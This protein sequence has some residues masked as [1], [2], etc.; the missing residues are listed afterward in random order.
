MTKMLTIAIV[1]GAALLMGCSDGT[2]EAAQPTALATSAAP[3]AVPVEATAVPAEPTA[4]PS[5]PTVDN[6]S[7]DD[8]ATYMEKVSVL[9]YRSAD[10]LDRAT[11]ATTFSDFWPLRDEMAKI[12]D[13]VRELDA[14]PCAAGIQSTY[15]QGLDA[16][17]DALAAAEEG[18]VDTANSKLDLATALYN[19]AT[20]QME[21]LGRDLGLL[22]Y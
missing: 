1:L 15:L 21:Q 7:P 5:V 11:N 20:E 14:P 8:A 9:A 10:V 17:V 22:G 13:D 4:A 16:M 3:T 6:C 19:S 2:R 18:D 12:R